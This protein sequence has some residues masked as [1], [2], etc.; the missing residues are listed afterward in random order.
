MLHVAFGEA[1]EELLVLLQVGIGE[2]LPPLPRL[3]VDP[4]DVVE[5]R[6]VVARH[7]LPVLPHSLRRRGLDVLVVPLGPGLPPDPRLLSAALI[8]CV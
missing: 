7:L 8:V 6:P 1:L 5:G 2:V 3:Q 4:V